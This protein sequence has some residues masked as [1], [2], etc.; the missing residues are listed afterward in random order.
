MIKISNLK[1]SKLFSVLFVILLL[2]L[3]TQ[4]VFGETT[5]HTGDPE[6]E[7][8]R[9]PT[10]TLRYAGDEVVQ[11]NHVVIK[12][13]ELLKIEVKGSA[14]DGDLLTFSVL[15]KPYGANFNK[16]DDITYILRWQPSFNQAGVYD[17]I[18]FRVSDGKVTVQESIKIV[19]KN[20]NR[21]P[22]LDPIGNKV[23]GEGETLSF[24]IS[25]SD[26]DSEDHG[27]LIYSASNLPK[28]ANFDSDT[29]KFTWK[30]GFDQAGVYNNIKFTVSDGKASDSRFI[31]I[32]VNDVTIAPENKPPRIIS[33][34]IT[35]AT[36]N[37]LYKYDVDATDPD[38]DA[39][40]YSL[41]T[42]PAGMSINA[43]TGLISWTPSSS[44]IGNNNVVV[45]VSDNKGGTAT[46]SFTIVAAADKPP[47][48]KITH[49][50]SEHNNFVE[51]FNV[52]II[53]SATD[54]DNDPLT[55]TV[56][57][58]DGQST[59]GNV[60]NNAI[61]LQ[62]VYASAGNYKITVTASDGVKTGSDNID[63]KVWAYGFNITNL[64]SYNNSDF[65]NEDTVFFRFEP[66][67]INFVVV[68]KDSRIPVA[69]LITHVY[70]FNDAHP[71]KNYDLTPF[72]GVAN[73]VEIVDGQ[74]KKLDGSYYYFMEHLPISD[75]ILGWNIVF[76]FARNETHAGE[77]TLQIQI[78]NNPIQLS[79]FPVVVLDQKS[80]NMLFKDL[81]LNDFVSDVETPNNEIVWSFSGMTNINVQLLP[82]NIARFS[83]P[84]SFQGTETITATADD[85]D[86]STASKNILVVSGAPIVIVLSPNGGETLFGI[87]P[88]TWTATD[89]QNEPL[90]I[91]IQY[92]NDNGATW[93]TIVSNIPNTGNY[94]WNTAG[95][96]Q[97][98]QYLIKV[99]ATDPHG[100]S[101][102]DVSDGV[103]TILSGPDVGLSVKIIAD[104]TSGE[105][106]L[107]VNFDAQVTGGNAPFTF[108]WDFD[109]DGVADSTEKSPR[110]IFQKKKIHTVTLQVTDFDG[111]KATDTITIDAREQ[112][113]ILP[114]GKIQIDQIRYLEEIRAGEDLE[115][116]VSIENKN[117]LET[118]ELSATVVIPD[119]GLRRKVGNEK[120]KS[121]ETITK[122]VIIP[123]P[124]NTKPGIYDVMIAVND[125]DTNRVRYRQIKII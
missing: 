1:I 27:T 94:L 115:V 117:S 31:T 111:D 68:Q 38:G 106:P 77:Q 45:R 63:I 61:N 5:D 41:T 3:S 11:D 95:L 100:I 99:I 86:G 67:Y 22:S 101:G 60:V 18:I 74:P 52:R 8:N 47:V 2:I 112:P 44:Q 124:K 107:T 10:L 35:T 91:T 64:K 9:A 42:K 65:T 23:V 73:G 72:N 121:G 87:V 28:G 122:R 13:N 43:N 88:I 89:L 37:V 24:G 46:Q 108:A 90:T 104:K 116:L 81:N 125:H 19:V 82:N 96:P 26:P 76:V 40:T 29:R 83:A 109:E 69:N 59:N 120:L 110:V 97:G 118:K 54:P 105:A 58:G 85:T 102:F 39:L 71:K 12:E 25:G 78:L 113:S 30:P 48:V 4:S 21:A 15:N 79:D 56:N 36:E 62:H 6:R 123:I 50:D 84:L 16:I 103:F 17:D 49:P 57:F 98:N 93:N 34:P 55:Y 14:P 70:M 66:L 51:T 75:D 33:T 119:L 92:S 7:F 53:A 114:R 20:T 80:N 32:T